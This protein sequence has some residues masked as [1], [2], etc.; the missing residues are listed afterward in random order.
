MTN[1]KVKRN[2]TGFKRVMDSRQLNRTLLAR[3][4]LI[5]R[6]NMSISAILHHLIGM[7]SQVPTSPYISLWSR[8]EKFQ[9]DSLSQ[10]LLDRGAIRMALMRSTI[11]LVTGYDGL[12]IRPLMQSVME[13]TLQGNFGSG[14]TVL[15]YDEFTKT[16]RNLVECQPRTLNELGK[17]LKETWV[18]SKPDSLAAA[19]R[20][21]VPLVQIPPRGIWGAKGKAVY[22]SAEHWLSQ[23]LVTDYSL[24]TL[25]LRYLKAYGP[26]TISDIQYWSGLTQIR[27]VIAG[28]RDQLNIYLNEDGIELFDV[29]DLEIPENDT[30]VPVRFLAEFDNILLSHKNRSRIISEE[31]RDRVFT[32]NG[33][34][35]A[36]F[37]IDGFVQGLWRIENQSNSTTLIIEPFRPLLKVDKEELV[38]EGTKLIDFVHMNTKVKDIQFL[39]PSFN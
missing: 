11:F 27:E 35:K 31:Y 16:I 9:H 8:I 4:H 19:A 1:N 29:F 18:D 23:S 24:E 39:E 6:S 15:D 13:R 30:S 37:L 21:L 10:L 3:Q 36:T 34:I 5:K 2:D 25:I 33:I 12:S 28:L 26:A 17:I 7:Q 20:N 32:V 22:T 38:I 14:L